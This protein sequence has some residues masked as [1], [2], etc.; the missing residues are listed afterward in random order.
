MSKS[1]SVIGTGIIS[2]CLGFF[3]ARTMA[4]PGAED[5]EPAWELEIPAAA[6]KLWF[7]PADQ[8]DNDGE[9]LS[10][11]SFEELMAALRTA[12]TAEETLADFEREADIHLW[13]FIRRLRVPRISDDQLERIKAY[14]DVLAEEHPDSRVIR[15]K[16]SILAGYARPGSSI[17][18]FAGFITLFPYDEANYPEAGEPFEDWQ[19]DRM[20]AELDALLNLPESTGDFEAEASI[21]LWEMGYTLQRRIVSGDQTARVVAYLEELKEKYPDAVEMLDRQR[22]VVEN[23][24][25]G[26]VAPN[27][28]GKDTEGVE[29]EL[30]DYRGNIVVLVFSGQWCGPCRAEYPYQRA[31]LEAFRDKDVVLLSV[32]SDAKLETIRQAKIDE[33]LDYR[34]WW[35]GHSQPE[36]EAVA[37]GGPIATRWRVLG[38]PTIYVI[39]EEGVIRLADADGGGSLVATVDELLQEKTM[40][41]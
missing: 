26:Q 1:F 41:E 30:E 5:D 8:Y 35:D 29:F 9:Q 14:L 34:T 17:P 24:M 19:V 33:A 38:W 28:V 7:P 21:P 18:S 31:M 2:F 25:P 39:D 12:M 27:I 11:E 3:V 22:F 36:A 16:K 13:N 23:L 10:D 37:T 20:L 15:Q 6:A 4:V 32:N 40:R